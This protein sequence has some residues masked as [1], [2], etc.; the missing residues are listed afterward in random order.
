MAD[1]WDLLARLLLLRH[2]KRQE[3]IADEVVRGVARSWRYVRFHDL[4][5]SQVPFL[6]SALS[7]VE[8][9]FEQSQMATSSFL[10]E[11]RELATLAQGVDVPERP[12]IQPASF[13]SAASGVDVAK[14]ERELLNPSS[15]GVDI[16]AVEHL[17]AEPFDKGRAAADLMSA[18]PGAVKRAMPAPEDLAMASGLKGATGAAVRNAM[19]GGRGVALTEAQEDQ[20]ASGWQR[21]TDGDPCYFCALLAA[22]GPV[23]K[24]RRSFSNKNSKTGKAFDPNLA[25][26]ATGE[27]DG[28]AKVHNHCRCQLVP[29]FEGFEQQDAWGKVALRIWRKVTLEGLSGKDA[30][31]EYRRLY[32][33]NLKTDNPVSGD[34]IDELEVRAAIDRTLR[35]VPDG[36]ETAKFLKSQRRKLRAA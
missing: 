20:F 14:L 25:F 3:Q 24:R 21:V 19:N 17:W 26:E 12:V 8:T 2:R 22:N 30:M 11:Y 1:V 33:E 36:S 5:A 10:R 27:P 9:G 31:K 7:T 35:L 28:I 32:G 29:V 34:G 13:A 18:G 6:D 15:G 16:S 4:D 23:Y